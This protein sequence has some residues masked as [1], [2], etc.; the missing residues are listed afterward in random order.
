[1]SDAE[2]NIHYAQAKQVPDMRRGFTIHTSYGDI[3]V[4]AQEAAPFVALAETML[5][6]R[7]AELEAR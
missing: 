7:L 1:M 6:G 2:L 3:D 4:S 5:A